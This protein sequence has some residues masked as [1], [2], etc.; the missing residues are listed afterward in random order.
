MVQTAGQVLDG[1]TVPRIG[2]LQILELPSIGM[3]G[4]EHWPR[5]LRKVGW[6]GLLQLMAPLYVGWTDPPASRLD[7]FEA[8]S[9][10]RE[11]IAWR[12]RTAYWKSN[13]LAGDSSAPHRP[14]NPG[15]DLSAWPGGPAW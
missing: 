10:V 7:Q 11:G 12:S 1:N 4:R 2:P 9:T 15:R 8:G 14:Y 6:Q 3:M 13:V 5:P